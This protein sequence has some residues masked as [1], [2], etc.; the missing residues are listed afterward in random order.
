MLD[1]GANLSF[2]FTLKRVP[3]KVKDDDATYGLTIACNPFAPLGCSPSV[4]AMVQGAM[5]NVLSM[6][7]VTSRLKRRTS[8]ASMTQRVTVA[9]VAPQFSV[10]PRLTHSVTMKLGNA[11]R[12]SDDC[13]ICV[14]L[15]SNKASKARQV[16]E[17]ICILSERIIRS[18]DCATDTSAIKEPID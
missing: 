6:P 7:S 10:I 16:R 2:A 17:S 1:H 18:R 15:A 3:R 12:L 8:G 11:A 4:L 14:S 9:M 5:L 13:Q